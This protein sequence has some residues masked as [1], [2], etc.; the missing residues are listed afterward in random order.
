MEANSQYARMDYWDERFKTEKN[1]EW[2]SGLDAFQ[3]LI[4]P[5]ISK[6]SSIAH[7]GCGSSQVSMQLWDL[8]YTNIT[9]IDYSQVLIDNG[10][11]KYPCMKWVADDIT[12][13]KNCESS[14]FD[15]VFEKATIE[16]I[17]VNEKSAW[18]PSDSAL[19]NLEN[20][21]S[22]I[23]RVLKPNGMF[24]SVSFTQPHFRVPALLR[25]RNWSIEVFEF[26]ETFHYYVYVCRK[27]NSSNSELAQRYSSIAKSWLRPL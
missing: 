9:N 26:G 25:E 1:F 17:L 12:I 6:D 10:S 22:S 15:V 16:A 19:Q 8:G 23:C 7:V 2:L 3:H 27:G 5:L 18:E 24:I 21:F 4:T 11:L 14:S 13:L 20:I